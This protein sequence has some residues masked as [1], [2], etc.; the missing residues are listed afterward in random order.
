MDVPAKLRCKSEYEP[1][2]LCK[3]GNYDVCWYDDCDLCDYPRIEH[4]YGMM[5][6]GR[7][8]DEWGHYK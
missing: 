5:G 6:C 4:R 8:I 2:G 1:C 7:K 3:Y